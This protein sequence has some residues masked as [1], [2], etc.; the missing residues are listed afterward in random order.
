MVRDSLY[1][2]TSA[3]AGAGEKPNAARLDP[4]SVLAETF[5]N[6]RRDIWSMI[7]LGAS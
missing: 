5:R 2:R 6:C 7:A 1:C 4:A 3:S